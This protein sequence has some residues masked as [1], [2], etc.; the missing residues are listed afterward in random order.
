MPFLPSTE[1]D[2]DINTPTSIAADQLRAFIERIE[3]L[4]EEKRVTSDYIKEVY[5]EAKSTGFDVKAMRTVVRLR[6]IPETERAE[7][8]A[9]LDL[10]M[11]AIGTA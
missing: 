4:T 3:T 8:E 6:A 11:T 9:I 2:A 5:A 7:S 10:Y 1:V